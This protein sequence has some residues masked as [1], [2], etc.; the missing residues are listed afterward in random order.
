MFQ[1]KNKPKSQRE[2]VSP[3][4]F[5]TKLIRVSQWPK[6][7]TNHELSLKPTLQ[8][9]GLSCAKPGPKKSKITSNFKISPSHKS[10]PKYV[11]HFSNL[12]TLGNLTNPPVRPL[13]PSQ[14][15]KKSQIEF[16][17]SSTSSRMDTTL[18]KAHLPTWW[19]GGIIRQSLERKS[20]QVPPLRKWIREEKKMNIQMKG[21]VSLRRNQPTCHRAT[22]P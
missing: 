22:T 15:N 11:N 5:K 14:N 21:W 8:N 16:K 20:R 2:T 17:K 18:P 6:S 9:A 19:K 1:N 13:Y 4:K 10:L 7:N 12:R 3:R